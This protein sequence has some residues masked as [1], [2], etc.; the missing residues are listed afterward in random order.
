MKKY[1]VFVGS[2]SAAFLLL[3]ILSGLLLT[4]FYTSSMPWGKLSALSSQVE[5]GRATVIPPLV[6]ALLALGIAFG[7]TTLFSK[8]ASR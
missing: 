8:R 3:Q 6:I 1:L 5:F 7:V 2:F 4:L